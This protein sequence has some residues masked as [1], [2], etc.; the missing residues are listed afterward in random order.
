MNLVI[1]Q[2]GAASSGIGRT[3]VIRGSD[4]AGAGFFP[5][6]CRNLL[7]RM[8]NLTAGVNRSVIFALG[9]DIGLHIPDV[10]GQN[11]NVR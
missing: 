11:R 10:F 6:V 3:A 2:H 7:V 8:V 5:A 4:C 9:F 1:V